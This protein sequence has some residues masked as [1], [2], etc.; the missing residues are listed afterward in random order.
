[1]TLIWCAIRAIDRPHSL[2]DTADPADLPPEIIGH[3][4]CHLGGEPFAVDYLLDE[5]Q[6]QA[7]AEEIT[8]S[9]DD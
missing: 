9:I 7:T 3:Q 8:R 6:V 1:M 2:C 5:V 4:Q